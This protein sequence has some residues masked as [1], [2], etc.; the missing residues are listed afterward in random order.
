[1]RHPQG[2]TLVELNNKPI[3]ELRH[4]EAAALKTDVELYTPDGAFLK[5]S[6]AGWSDGS[7]SE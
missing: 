2:M 5:S 3:V 6:D 1:M 7:R 4:T